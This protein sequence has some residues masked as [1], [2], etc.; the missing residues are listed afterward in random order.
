MNLDAKA[1]TFR[2]FQI[3][4]S[5]LSQADDICGHFFCLILSKGIFG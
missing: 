2:L 4:L 5:F 3:K 1:W